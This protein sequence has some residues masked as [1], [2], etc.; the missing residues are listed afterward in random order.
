MATPNFNASVAQN[1]DLAAVQKRYS[2]YLDTMDKTT[3]QLAIN[4]AQR[5]R[6]ID[7]PMLQQT[8]ANA[9]LAGAASTPALAQ[10]LANTQ[11]SEYGAIANTLAQREAT[12]GQAIQGALPIAAEPQREAL[13]E[14]QFGLEAYRVPQELQLQQGRLDLMAQQNQLAAANQQ[15]QEFQA[16][17]NAQRTSPIY[18]P[19]LTSP[20][21]Y[22]TQGG[23]VRYSGGGYGGGYGAAGGAPA[24][25]DFTSGYSG[26]YAPPPPRQRSSYYGGGSGGGSGIGLGGSSSGYASGTSGIGL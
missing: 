2:D 22:T 25:Q 19:P 18:A 12:K 14:K 15:F 11:R 9:V 1:P 26:G 16:M 13:A 23:P 20:D 21:T 4:A 7:D 10:Q 24:G 17:V 3:G 8:K 5:V 6:D